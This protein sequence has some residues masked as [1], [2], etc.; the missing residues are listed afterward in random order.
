M[1]V[2]IVEELNLT[3]WVLLKFLSLTWVA[4]TWDSQNNIT[5]LLMLFE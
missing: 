5:H 4:R 3:L 2:V 1:C